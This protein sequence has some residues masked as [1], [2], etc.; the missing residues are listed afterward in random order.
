MDNKT[1]IKDL[2]ER[3]VT[4]ENLIQAL[5]LMLE[6]WS[7]MEKKAYDKREQEGEKGPTKEFYM[8]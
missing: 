6:A 2:E 5:S 8:V 7:D 1:R 4:L 3:V